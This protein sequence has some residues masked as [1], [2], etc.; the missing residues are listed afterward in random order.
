MA[1][2]TSDA[3][4]T[5]KIGDRVCLEAER[6]NGA[7]GAPRYVSTASAATNQAMGVKEQDEL[8]NDG[9]WAR[10]VF[11]V[12]AQST[13]TR[14]QNFKML[15]EQTGIDL[16]EAP[17]NPE[18]R[19][20]WLDAQAEFELHEREFDRAKGREVRYG[21]V[22]QLLHDAR[23]KW[24]SSS[25]QSVGG[26]GGSR[27]LLDSNAAESGWF[28]VMPRL[29]VHNEGERVRT[30]DPIVLQAIETGQRV[31]LSSALELISVEPSVETGA[32]SSFRLRLYVP[33]LPYLI[34]AC[35]AAPP[36]GKSMHP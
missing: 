4:E 33:T 3:V 8:E 28:R 25:R 36:N 20:A 12:Q 30:G 6:L 14:M 7:T 11:V 18:T 1:E 24:L 13:W 15:L 17:G 10:A 31:T 29:R 35:T 22:I 5:I 23:S 27:M 32:S 21:S 26:G 9:F 2:A 34:D 19:G 16:L